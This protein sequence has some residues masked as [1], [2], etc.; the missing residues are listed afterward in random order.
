MKLKG[1]LIGIFLILVITF[2]FATLVHRQK[3]NV[4]F[5]ASENIPIL[6]IPE[7]TTFELLVATTF[8][9]QLPTGSVLGSNG[10]EYPASA[11]NNSTR[12][13]VYNC[14]RDNPGVQFRG[15][16]NQLG[17]SMGLAEFHLGVLKKAGLISFFRD[18]KYKRFFVTKKFSQKKMRLISLLRHDTVKNIIKTILGEGQVAHGRLANQLSITSQAVTWQMTRLKKEKFV[19]VNRVCT[20]AIYSLEEAY[21]PVLAEIVGLITISASSE[22]KQ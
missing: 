6:E 10:A 12:A 5:P 18:G 20:K 8:T 21:I 22:R 7:R 15:I 14:I 3:A 19:Q 16:C 1:T 9:M 13:E 4:L 2:S 11:F 17:I